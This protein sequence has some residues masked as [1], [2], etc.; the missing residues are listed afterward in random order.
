MAITTSSIRTSKEA[1]ETLDQQAELINKRRKKDKKD[2][3]S[4]SAIVALAIASF[5]IDIAIMER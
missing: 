3:I 2:P 1:L 5:N 4:K